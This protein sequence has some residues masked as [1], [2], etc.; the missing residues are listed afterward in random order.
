[1]QK[2]YD[3]RGF[4]TNKRTINPFVVQNGGIHL[5]DA[6]PGNHLDMIALLA[7]PPTRLMNIVDQLVLVS[8][9]FWRKEPLVNDSLVLFS[10]N[11]R[12]NGEDGHFVVLF[13][14]LQREEGRKK[15][16]ARVGRAAEEQAASVERH[17][18]SVLAKS[19]L[20]GANRDRQRM[21]ATIERDGI[22]DGEERK[23]E[24][25]DVL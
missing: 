25:E 11:D 12:A 13:V 10:R 22:I 9:S 17:G 7:D 19:S 16:E 4:G 2:Q 21:N 14:G 3:S 24:R 6:T 15:S 23:R 18:N 1:M 20:D 5:L 8:E